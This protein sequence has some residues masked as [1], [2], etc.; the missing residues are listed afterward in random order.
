MRTAVDTSVLL[1]VFGADPQHGERSREALRAAYRAGALLVCD[2]AWAEV[3]AH[4]AEDGE[5]REMLG[6][7]GARFD[8]I[9]AE[10][11]ARPMRSSP[12]TAASIAGVSPSYG[13][14]TLRADDPAY[15][16]TLM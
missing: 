6:L 10:S 11:S 16:A 13:S 14:S 2:V 3:R 12:A 9:S 1:D 8:P 15:S 7:L 5:F 4:F